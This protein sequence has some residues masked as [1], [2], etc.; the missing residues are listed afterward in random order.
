MFRRSVQVKVADHASRFPA[1]PAPAVFHQARTSENAAHSAHPN[2]IRRAGHDRP[3][4]RREEKST[5]S[6]YLVRFRIEPV[7][8]PMEARPKRNNKPIYPGQTCVPETTVVKS[9]KATAPVKAPVRS[10]NRLV[11]KSI[12]TRSSTRV[13]LYAQRESAKPL[14]KNRSESWRRKASARVKNPIVESWPL[15][16]VSITNGK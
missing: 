8:T 10:L 13:G 15:T 14:R 1:L 12:G 3:W 4:G 6:T 5:R 11:T 2:S 16:R 9:N 7:W